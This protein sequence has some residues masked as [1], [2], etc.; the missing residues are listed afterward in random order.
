MA[1][2]TC[3]AYVVPA[4][5]TH[6]LDQII[7][8]FR[9]STLFQAIV[10]YVIVYSFGMSSFFS[11][12]RRL[13]HQYYVAVQFSGS[14]LYI[15]FEDFHS[16]IYG[17]FYAA[18]G[19]NI[20]M[21]DIPR[22]A[23]FRAQHSLSEVRWGGKTWMGAISIFRGFAAEEKRSVRAGPRINIVESLSYGCEACYPILLI[24]S[25]ITES[26]APFFLIS[27]RARL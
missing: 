23:V 1:T 18:F 26:L 3:C 21:R 25:T 7:V 9:F 15:V 24:V 2:P 13:T 4:K 8:L 10:N 17:H 27:R 6:V 22:I 5:T 11:K 20:A 19:R 12:L 14:I 16:S